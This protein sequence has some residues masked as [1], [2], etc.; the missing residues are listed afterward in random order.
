LKYC[1]DCPEI[2]VVGKLIEFPIT[3]VKDSEAKSQGKAF[4]RVN[5]P[6]TGDHRFS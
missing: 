1:S 3:F 6:D 4:V 2:T 5:L